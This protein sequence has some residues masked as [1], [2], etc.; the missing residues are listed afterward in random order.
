MGTPILLRHAF[1][2]VAAATALAGLATV[3]GAAGAVARAVP[4][5]H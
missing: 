4:A 5:A 2:T 1:V 3:T